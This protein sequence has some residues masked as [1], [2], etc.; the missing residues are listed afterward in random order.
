MIAQL[1]IN[2]EGA[3]MQFDET[4]PFESIKYWNIEK[5]NYYFAVQKEFIE[6]LMDKSFSKLKQNI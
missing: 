4:S 1:C 6:N 2:K 5:K 3:L